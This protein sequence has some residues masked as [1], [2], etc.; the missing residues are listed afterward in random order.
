M[1]KFKIKFVLQTLIIQVL[2]TKCFS[3]ELSFLFTK[4]TQLKMC[5][6]CRRYYDLFEILNHNTNA[7]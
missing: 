1:T 2:N 6:F 5:H 4:M 3:V 7:I